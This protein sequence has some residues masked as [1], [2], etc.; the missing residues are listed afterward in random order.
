MLRVALTMP[1]IQLLI[2]GYIATTDIKNMPTAVM[3]EDQ[4]SMSRTYM[5]HVVNSR[6]IST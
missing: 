2:F 5:S 6:N 4:S 3:D 1:V